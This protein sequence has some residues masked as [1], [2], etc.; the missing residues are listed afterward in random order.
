MEDEGANEERCE[1]GQLLCKIEPKEY[2]EIKCRRC[3]R[4]H[5]VNIM[6]LK[7]EPIR[8]EESPLTSHSSKKPVDLSWGRQSNRTEMVNFIAYYASDKFHFPDCRWAWKIKKENR[9]NFENREQALKA[10]YKPCRVCKP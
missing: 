5:Y 4:L 6:K 2:I 8:I 1:C 9:I 10:G 3:K 7:R